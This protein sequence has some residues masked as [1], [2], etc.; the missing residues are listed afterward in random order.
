VPTEVWVS[1]H[2]AL[3]ARFRDTLEAQL[4]SSSYFAAPVANSSDPMI[5]TI[6]RALYWQKVNRK[7]NF[8]YVVI[9]TDKGSKYLGVSIGSCWEEDLSEC[10]AQVVKDAQQAWARRNPAT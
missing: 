2:D 5:L 4:S 9:F 3:T 7:T 10:V 1:G 8:Q 6:P